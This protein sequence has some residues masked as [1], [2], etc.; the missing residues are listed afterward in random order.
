MKNINDHQ[1]RHEMLIDFL[2]QFEQ[3][4]SDGKP[5]LPKVKKELSSDKVKKTSLDNAHNRQPTGLALAKCDVS[6]F[7]LR[8]IGSA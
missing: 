7:R 1:V 5:S 4:Q 2:S 6:L 3:Y 8:M